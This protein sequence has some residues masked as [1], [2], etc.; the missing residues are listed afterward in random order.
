MASPEKQLKKGFT[1]GAAAA[2]AVKG[3]LCLLLDNRA[4][5]TVR[6]DF[7]GGGHRDIDIH[8][9]RKVNN[10]A[11]CTVIKDAGD[12]PDITHK[13]EVGVRVAIKDSQSVEVEISGGKGVGRVTRPGLEIPPGNPAITVGPRKMIRMAV[14][15]I[16]DQFDLSGLS[17]SVE[18]F[19]PEGE[20][21]ARKTLNARLGIVGGISIL[22]TTGVVTPM[23]HEA[24]TA[25]IRAALSV[26]RAGGVEEVFFTTGRRSERYGRQIWPEAPEEAFIQ[27]GDFFQMS[28]AA[29]TAMGVESIVLIVFFGKAVKMAYGAPHTHAAK[30]AMCME[31]LSQW[32]M[33]ITGDQV[34]AENVRKANTARQVF[35]ML[36]EG[37][38]KT[39]ERGKVIEK[40]G[41]GMIR[42]AKKFMLQNTAVRSVILDFDGQVVFDSN[43]RTMGERRGYGNDSDYRSGAIL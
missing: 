15:R 29:A 21:L 8:T 34:L 33:E 9:C 43:Q 7:I 5:S 20:I 24:Y 13:A 16:C 19:V 11:V 39:I 4:P 35:C 40:V 42:S 22:G 28:L 25:T 38:F 2:A 6:V 26:A 17:V 14:R 3:A 32:V 12:D 27:I 37:Q 30:S 23:S 1:T 36:N 41:M 31:N 18:V 10:S